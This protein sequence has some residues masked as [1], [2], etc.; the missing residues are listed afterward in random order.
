[1]TTLK[2]DVA[3]RHVLITGA[4][5]GLGA[6]LACGFARRGATLTLMG[7]DA[8]RLAAVSARCR[9]LGGAP[10]AVVCDVRDAQ[11]MAGALRGA[12]ERQALD[13]VI[14]NA[15]IGGEQVMSRDD[16]E[17]LELA[18]EVVSV[19]LLGVIN[20]VAPMQEIFTRRRRGSLVLVSSMAAFEG[21]AAAPSYAASKAAVRIY[22][23]GLRRL[24]AP[25]GV[26][27]TV[28]TPGFVATPMS[29]SLPMSAPFLWSAERAARRILAGLDR[30]EYEIAFP[31][32]MRVGIALARL[33]PTQLVD[34]AMRAA[35]QGLEGRG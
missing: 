32:Q 21:L 14:A 26:L 23:H 3:T 27:V 28:V 8:V 29:A 13:V 30:G 33:L 12:D 24:L 6:E 34:Y 11:A 17:P 5:S 9:A 31:W 15:G 19:N 10:E 1:M 20:T 18:R 4:S 2:P 25:F 22:G 35:Q 16:Q 7:R